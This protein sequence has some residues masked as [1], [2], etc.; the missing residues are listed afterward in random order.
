M[1]LVNDDFDNLMA[2]VDPSDDLKTLKKIAE[3][4][5][6][7][8][9]LAEELSVTKKTMDGMIAEFGNMFGGGS[10]NEMAKSEV[11]DK[12][13]VKEDVVEAAKVKSATSPAAE[14]LGLDRLDEV[15]CPV[16][17]EPVSMR[18]DWLGEG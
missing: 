14:D 5:K 10:D 16:L 13:E 6:E 8:A 7:K 3:L 15:R 18:D 17:R 11:V 2:A 4:E 1:R 12:L 9:I